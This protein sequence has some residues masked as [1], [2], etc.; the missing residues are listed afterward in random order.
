MPAKGSATTLNDRA[1]EV[2]AF[3]TN[4]LIRNIEPEIQNIDTNLRKLDDAGLEALKGG[5]GDEI[6]KALNESKKHIERVRTN[7]EKISKFLD[8]KLGKVIEAI[9]DNDNIAATAEKM[10]KAAV[11]AA[12]KKSN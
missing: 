3:L 6:L 10:Q 8:E 5:R 11:D 1:L 2:A 9:K 4:V 12:L 7:T